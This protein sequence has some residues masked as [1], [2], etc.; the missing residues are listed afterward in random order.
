MLEP[1]IADIGAYEFAG[2]SL[3]TT[4]PVILGTNPAGIDAG[5]VLPS[6]AG[7]LTVTF[8]EAINVIDA[9]ASSNYELRWAGS[10]ELFGSGDDLLFDLL[11][12]YAAGID[13]RFD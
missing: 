2:S 4:P 8:S 9:V 3:D 6:F 13:D 12:S 5:G 1:G 7:L 10:D 11:P